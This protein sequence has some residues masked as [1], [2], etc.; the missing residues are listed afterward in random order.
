MLD[1][2]EAAAF[3]KSDVIRISA[4]ADARTVN[5]QVRS[6]AFISPEDESSAYS[7]IKSGL[8]LN[9]LEMK[10][11]YSEDMLGE[12]W[13]PFLKNELYASF[14]A[15]QTFLEG[16]V[17]SIDGDVLKISLKKNGKDVL[18]QLG[19]DDFIKKAALESFSKNIAVEF[20]SNSADYDEESYF[21]DVEFVN[22]N[23]EMEQA[24][25]EWTK[26]EHFNKTN[27]NSIW[28]N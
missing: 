11:S 12:A 18:T 28:K 19:V 15:A 20:I 26:Q 6:S 25:K 3:S 22:V 2:K 16:A 7:Q 9:N 17:Y 23:Q 13:F 4:D 21:W 27:S 14:A 10:L 24:A 5:M 8:R 1:E